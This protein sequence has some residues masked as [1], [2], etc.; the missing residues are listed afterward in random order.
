[1]LID[2]NTQKQF[3]SVD[4]MKL[5]TQIYQHHFCQGNKRFK[6]FSTEST[7]TIT[8]TTKIINIIKGE[9]Q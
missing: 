8:N 6:E 4:K 9:K 5:Y 3:N 1:M 7:T 2:V